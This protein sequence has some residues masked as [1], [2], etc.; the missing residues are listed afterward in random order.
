MMCYE[1]NCAITEKKPKIVKIM[2]YIKTDAQYKHKDIDPKAIEQNKRYL[3][4]EW[5]TW[6]I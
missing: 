1:W 5:M 2:Q 6:S 4:E 3:S